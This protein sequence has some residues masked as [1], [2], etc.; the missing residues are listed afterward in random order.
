MNVIS[1]LSPKKQLAHA[2]VFSPLCDG[3]RGL[4]FTKERRIPALDQLFPDRK[5]GIR[6]PDELLPDL[7]G[8]N[9]LT[10]AGNPRSRQLLVLV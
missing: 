6:T 5:S 3:S 2:G 1:P 9:R 7:E 10:P 8:A 4:D